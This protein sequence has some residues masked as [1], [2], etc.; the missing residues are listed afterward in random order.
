MFTEPIELF[1]GESREIPDGYDIPSIF[2]HDDTAYYTWSYEYNYVSDHTYYIK[3]FDQDLKYKKKNFINL[4]H[5]WLNKRE[6]LAVFHFH[7]KIYL[8]TA[9]KKFRRRL[10][11]VET[12]NKSKKE[13]FCRLFL[14]FK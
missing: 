3:Q 10:L 1:Q 11:Y 9:E 14:I 5:G 13:N 8:F 7:D 6:L 4:R 2:G 12:V